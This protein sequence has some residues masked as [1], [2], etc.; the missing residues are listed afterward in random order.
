MEIF[1]IKNQASYFNFIIKIPQTQ[2]L[3]H[4]TYLFKS[5]EYSVLDFKSYFSNFYQFIYSQTVNYFIVINII[6]N[7]EII[8]LKAE[9]YD[10][11]NWFNYIFK[12]EG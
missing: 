7:K 5:W 6:F 8:Y 4:S 1:L 12:G 9:H 3:N 10:F 11:E 2:I